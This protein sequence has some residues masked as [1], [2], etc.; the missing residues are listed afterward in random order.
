MNTSDKKK[1][2]EFIQ[3][4]DKLYKKYNLMVVC[5]DPYCGVNIEKYDSA[6]IQHMIDKTKRR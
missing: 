6:I 2:K 1:Q 4:L 5:E 3:E